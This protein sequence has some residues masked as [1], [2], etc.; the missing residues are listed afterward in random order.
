M[1]QLVINKVIILNILIECIS[2]GQIALLERQL[3]HRDETIRD[4]LITMQNR[5]LLI[6]AKRDALMTS[7]ESLIELRDELTETQAALHNANKIINDG[8]K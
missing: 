2:E 6:A 3:A 1:L 7:P 5:A 4:Q 8:K